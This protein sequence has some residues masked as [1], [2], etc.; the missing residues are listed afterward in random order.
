MRPEKDPLTGGAYKLGRDA[1]RRVNDEVWAVTPLRFFP[2]SEQ[3]KP[4]TQTA[5]PQ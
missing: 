1:A 5:I 2:A 3:P 4:H